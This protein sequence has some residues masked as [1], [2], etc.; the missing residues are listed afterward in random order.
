LLQKIKNKRWQTLSALL[1][2]DAG[3]FPLNISGIHKQPTAIR[4]NIHSV[5]ESI[6]CSTVALARVKGRLASSYG[7]GPN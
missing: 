5:A 6:M 2:S 4:Y 7:K 3:T 1:R